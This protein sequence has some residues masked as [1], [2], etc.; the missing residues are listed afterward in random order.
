MK[1]IHEGGGVVIPV[2]L[3]THLGTGTAPQIRSEP[4][5]WVELT[6]WFTQD[7]CFVWLRG[8]KKYYFIL[9]YHGRL[10]KP[11]EELI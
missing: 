4:Y 1:L 8:K 10:A 2:S 9:W 7:V 6:C 3:P 5:G 11:G